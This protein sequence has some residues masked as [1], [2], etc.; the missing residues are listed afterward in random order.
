MNLLITGGAGFIGSHFTERLLK[1][2]SIK[3]VIVL[4]SLTYAGRKSNLSN[5]FVDKRFEFVRGDIC[6][7]KIVGSIARKVDHIVNFAAESHVDRSIRDSSLFVQT[8][9]LGTHTLLAAAKEF[10][11]SRFLQVSTDEVYGSIDFGSAA[12]DARLAP[13]SPYSASK[14]SADLLVHAYHVTH[15]LDT[16][17]TRSSNNYG[18]RQFPEKLIPLSIQNATVKGRIYLH[19]SG[20]D[21]RDWIHVEDYCD[22]V[23]AALFR[24]KSG[25]TYNFGGG[26]E[27]TNLEIANLILKQLNLDVDRIRFSPNRPG[28]D[29]RYSINSEKAR[30]DLGFSPKIEFDKGI[31]ETIDWYLSNHINR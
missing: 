13:S 21:V 17:I 2:D 16:V 10:G 7:P 20:L 28:H 26:N 22:G 11:V 4:D 6:D 5:C 1:L 12:E 25:E 14:A 8:N 30:R 31:V 18:P 29:V 3:K 19:G 23:I 15:D 27:K 24:G 9:I